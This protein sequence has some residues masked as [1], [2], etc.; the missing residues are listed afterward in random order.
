MKQPLQTLPLR[1]LTAALVGSLALAGIGSGVS[2]QAAP[3][4]AR[5]VAPILYKNC[6][7][8]HRPGGLGPM[9]LITYE[10]A[11]DVTAELKEKVGGGIM[12][13]WH[14]VAPHGTFVNDRR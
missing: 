5:D 12:P 2:A 3:T 8:C 4:F 13:P 6:T 7:S 1:C 11:K 14:A 10:D 9:S